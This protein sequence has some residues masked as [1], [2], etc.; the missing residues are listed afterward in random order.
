MTA[1]NK[2][3]SEIILD[4]DLHSKRIA[5][6]IKVNAE[7]FNEVFAKLEFMAMLY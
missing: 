3:P 5:D 7:K 1:K 4:E 2:I 6:R